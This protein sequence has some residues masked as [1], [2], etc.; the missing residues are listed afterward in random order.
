MA[1]PW[2]QLSVVGP[3]VAMFV[4]FLCSGIRMPFIPIA[5]FHLSSFN[6]M[7]FTVMVRR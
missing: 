2:L 6:Y 3:I 5:L 1:V 7:C 4:I